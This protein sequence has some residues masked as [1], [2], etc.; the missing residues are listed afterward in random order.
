MACF[1]FLFLLHELASQFPGIKTNTGTKSTPFKLVINQNEIMM[2]NLICYH[3]LQQTILLCV[4]VSQILSL[5]LERYAINPDEANGKKQVSFF[6][7]FFFC[8][9]KKIVDGDYVVQFYRLIN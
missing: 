7:A 5:L 4:V 3:C 2:M 9:E 8:W 6:F 1:Y